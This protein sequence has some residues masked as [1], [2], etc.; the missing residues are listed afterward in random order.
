MH[1]QLLCSKK[2]INWLPILWIIVSG[3][4]AYSRLKI[5]TLFIYD[6]F[7]TKIIESIWLKF[8]LHIPYIVQINLRM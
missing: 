7:S 1:I 4:I 6:S 2:L 3:Q 5:K 8:C